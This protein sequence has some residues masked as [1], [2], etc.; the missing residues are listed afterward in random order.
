M[1]GPIVCPCRG[2]A[3]SLPYEACCGRFHRAPD[4]GASTLKDAPDLVR[5]RFSAFSLGL[6]PF[7]RATES[8]SRP[9]IDALDPRTRYKRLEILDADVSAGTPRVLFSVDVLHRGAD[10]SFVELSS[11][12][13][14]Q[15][16][17][18]YLIGLT[19]KK[20]LGTSLAPLAIP[21]FEARL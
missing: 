9:R 15:G 20:K 21:D 17:L 11:F 8:A 16:R 7:V 10:A 13:V 18:V 14:E 4:L 6:L 5:A 19:Q 1:A 3:E 2:P 12:A